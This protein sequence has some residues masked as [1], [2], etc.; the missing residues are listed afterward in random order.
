MVYNK[1]HLLD[2]SWSN[3]RSGHTFKDNTNNNNQTKT[4]AKVEKLDGIS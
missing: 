4:E 2:N 3:A 1:I